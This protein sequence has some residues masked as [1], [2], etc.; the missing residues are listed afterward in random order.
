[1][2]KITIRP[3]LPLLVTAIMGGMT[4][5]I[6]NDYDLSDIDTT[7]RVNVD[8][9]VV[10]INI[11]KI[12]LSNIFDIK[13]GDRLQ[14]VDGVYAVTEDGTFTSSDIS[15]NSIHMA[16]PSV[17]SSNVE[18]WAYEVNGSNSPLRALTELTFN[19]YTPMED[20]NFHAA[21]VSSYI[22]S[23]GEI[24]CDFSFTVR[25]S[26][27]Q[28][29]QILNTI[30]I[31]D[32]ELQLP[33]GLEFSSVPADNFKYDSNTGVFKILDPVTSNS[34][35]TFDLTFGISG[36]DASIA[37]NYQYDL[38]TLDLE[39]QVGIA[40]GKIVVNLSN[41]DPS[42]DISTIGR[43][44]LRV[45]YGFTD[46]N[47]TSFSGRINYPIDGF[48]VSDV[49]LTDLP[50]ILSQDET[51]IV[52]ANPQ[53]FISLN[54]PLNTYEAYATTGIT[55]QGVRDNQYDEPCALDN[56]N[57]TIGRPHNYTGIYNYLLSPTASG[58]MTFPEFPDPE[59][60][61]Y[62]SLSNVLAGAGL[63]DALHITFTDPKLPSQEITNL[64]L[65]QSLG[66]VEGK[67]KFVAPLQFGD[68]STIVYS[69]T[70]SGWSS[71]D[72]DAVTIETLNV[73]LNITS[74]LPIN[75]NLTGYPIDKN[76]NRI[77]NVDIVGAEIPAKA[78][79][80]PLQISITGEI[81]GLDGIVF[82]ARAVT[83]PDTAPLSPDMSIYLEKVRPV[84]SGY[85]QKEL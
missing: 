74:E 76:G 82:Q 10:P 85:Y 69:D 52:I 60:V 34:A 81:T 63:P 24:G 31:N 25:V 78:Q 64:P 44:N 11:D 40:G 62:K 53:I 14:V 56:G 36:I 75:C 73:N 57:F 41:L 35:G 23:L 66:K 8:N 61:G 68:G 28:L 19:L 26:I 47:V 77:N 16:A 79:N 42:F 12:T 59:H 2:R 51:N 80:H 43:I 72:L 54:N 83:Q 70:E 21:N 6:D 38:H 71:E 39:G 32:L 17:P 33:R 22:E 7:V 46:I 65:G 4:S 29:A 45:D 58:A 84:V 13:E 18:I 5:C 15:I 9:L 20:Y 55:I 67:Y 1:M 37:A 30:S 50:D 27:P 48:N 3:Y 49:N